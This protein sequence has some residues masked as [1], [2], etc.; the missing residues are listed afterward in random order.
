MNCCGPFFMKSC[1]CSHQVEVQ[2]S[3]LAGRGTTAQS[4]IK[5]DERVVCSRLCAAGGTHHA[6]HVGHQNTGAHPD[7]PRDGAGR[8][9]LGIHWRRGVHGW[10]GR[11]CH[12]VLWPRGHALAAIMQPLSDVAMTL[13]AGLPHAARGLDL[14]LLWILHVRLLH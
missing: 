12:V 13:C 11:L 7:P 1:T 10:H 5:H 14:Y 8:F 4:C 2:L 6:G 3:A 9:L